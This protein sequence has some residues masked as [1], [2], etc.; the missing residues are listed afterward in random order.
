MNDTWRLR[1][2]IQFDATPTTESFRTSRT[3]DGDRTWFSLGATY[4]I[5]EKLDLDL[6]ATYIDVAS[7]TIDLPRGGGGALGSN[8]QMR[9]TTDGSVGIAAVGLKYKF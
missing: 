6:G 7:G 1:G 3:P 9:A 8:G 2:G 5:N 4:S